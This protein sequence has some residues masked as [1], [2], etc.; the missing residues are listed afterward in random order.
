M[1]F[2]RLLHAEWTK[3]RTVRGWVVGLLVGAAVILALGLMPSRQG[4]CGQYGPG[5]ECVATKGPDGQEVTDKFTFVHRTLT[6]DGTL[7]ARVASMTGTLPTDAPT[8]REGL[9]P[10]AKAG[11]I[12]KDGTGQGSAY[13]AVLLTGEHGVRMQYNY[14]H[15]TGRP[16]GEIVG[17]QPGWLRLSRTGDTVTAAGSPDGSS[18]TTVGTA[19]LEGLPATVTAGLFVASPQYS[20][21][22]NEAV[23]LSGTMGGPSITT[24]TFDQLGTSGAW[25]ADPWTGT[26]VGGGGDTAGGPADAGSP[27]GG[28]AAGGNGSVQR[29]QAA[30]VGYRPTAGGFALT[31]SG[32]IAPAVSGAAGGGVT[33]SQTLIG[34]FV[35][36]I[37]VVVVGAMFVTAEFRRG[38]IRTTLTAGPRRGRVLAAKAVVLGAATFVLGLVVAAVVVTFGQDVLR[39]NGVYVRPVSAATELRV[40]AGTAALLAAC[41]V[42]A[43][44]L[45][46]LLRRSVT[47]VTVSIVVIVLPYLLSVTV[48]P[49]R[50]AEWL[51][52]VSPAAA[53]AVQQ[54]EPRYEQVANIY[55]PNDGY[56][57]LE[58]W[59][60]FAV[61]ALWVA[62]VLGAA[63]VTLRGRDA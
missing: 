10:W 29:A 49:L 38:M 9:A 56:F 48:L 27:G 33:I 11:L 15:D 44:G 58:P 26:V 37:V 53:F 24:G 13:A 63:T 16:A 8:T 46:T 40:I 1:T 34:T 50:A 35:G 12:M 42:L 45:G 19:R 20:E 5:S 36:L 57:P 3:L 62:L 25:S 17:A 31:G 4:S 22:V 41:A 14:A 43:L 39:D 51:L 47:A 6:G 54:S 55:A 18:W 7:T 21:Q 2:L 23:V 59:A 30:P 60:G 28:N 32:D 61:L 52:R